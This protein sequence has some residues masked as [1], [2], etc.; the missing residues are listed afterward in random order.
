MS[1]LSIVDI[2][3]I[4]VPGSPEALERKMAEA[5]RLLGEVV[6]EMNQAAGWHSGDGKPELASS[7][8]YASGQVAAA[9]KLIGMVRLAVLFVKERR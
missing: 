7:Y 1:H 8:S 3:N 6:T 2:Q 5:A 9:E 4:K